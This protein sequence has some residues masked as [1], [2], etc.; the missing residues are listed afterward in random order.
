MLA[1]YKR[2]G[3]ARAAWKRGCRDSGDTGSCWRIARLHYAPSKSH[4]SALHLHSVSSHQQPSDEIKSQN[5]AEDGDPRSHASKDDSTPV[6]A[7]SLPNDKK[8]AKYAMRA[9]TDDASAQGEACVAAG[10]LTG[11]REWWK[12]GCSKAK[13]LPSCALF[14]REKTTRL[15]KACEQDNDA[16]SC[17]NLGA[18]SMSGVV[19][20]EKNPA[21]AADFLRRACTGGH[22]DACYNLAQLYRKQMI[23]TGRENAREAARYFSLACEA[24]SAAGCFNLAYLFQH[25]IGCPRDE[26]LAVKV[27]HRACADTDK[28][29]ADACFNLGVMTKQVSHFKRAC[30]LGMAEACRYANPDI[31]SAADDNEAEPNQA[32]QPPTNPT[33]TTAK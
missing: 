31:T 1:R 24:G 13:Y 22:A 27:Y 23:G 15:L 4:S 32:H 9:C 11:D 6:V 21:R 5:V 12:R 2:L 30:D 8:A 20:G 19:E 7:P 14:T 26:S 28:P 29:V 33:T 10:W 16:T 25:G 3:E 18:L 17:Y